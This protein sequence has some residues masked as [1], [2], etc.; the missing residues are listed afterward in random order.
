MGHIR[1]FLNV[2]RCLSGEG[3][4]ILDSWR[5]QGHLVYFCLLQDLLEQMTNPSP[6]QAALGW[7]AAS[8]NSCVAKFCVKKGE[9]LG[10]YWGLALFS[11]KIRAS[12][13]PPLETQDRFRGASGFSVWR[14]HTIT[15]SGLASAQW[16]LHTSSRSQARGFQMFS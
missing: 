11:G 7:L 2:S 14:P 9:V 5:G 15:V 4:S 8:K 1:W 3:T 6:S 13:P 16:P 12:Q 10:L